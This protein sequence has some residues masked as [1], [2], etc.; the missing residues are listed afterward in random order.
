MS[1]SSGDDTFTLLISQLASKRQLNSGIK[2]GLNTP[3]KH[4]GGFKPQT[5]V[6]AQP[7]AQTTT[8]TPPAPSTPAPDVVS[9]A[10]A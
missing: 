7:Q 6:V 10:Y 2:P 5:Q 3:I 9:P 4:S 1:N 8:T